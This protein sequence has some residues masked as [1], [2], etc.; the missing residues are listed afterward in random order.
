M[1]SARAVIHKCAMR[2]LYARLN[3]RFGPKSDDG[4]TRR[5]MIQRSLAAAAAVLLSDRLSAFQRSGPRVVVV[6]GGF[7]GL[8]AAYELSHAGADVI[9]LEARNRLGGRVLSFKDL[10]PGGNVEGGAELIGSN[11]PVWKR[12]KDRFKLSFLDVTDSD[13]RGADRPRRAQAEREGIRT[14]VGRHGNGA[15]AAGCRGGEDRRSVRRVGDAR[16]PRSSIAARS[17]R[18]STRSTRRRSAAPGSKRRWPRTT[19]SGPPGRVISATS[20]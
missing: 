7:A 8:A 4:L 14:A 12:Y 3:E 13:E 15:V 11:H 2:S 5:D 17:A 18:G 6:G 20:R 1:L 16:M 10:V 19:A 9:V